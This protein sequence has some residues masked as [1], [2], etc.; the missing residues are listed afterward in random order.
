[1]SEGRLRLQYL[2]DSANRIKGDVIVTSGL[3][4]YYP[5]GLVI[6]TVE[7]GYKRQAASRPRPAG[8]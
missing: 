3:G 1:M 6:G 2:S 4:G 5:A 7:D 8:A